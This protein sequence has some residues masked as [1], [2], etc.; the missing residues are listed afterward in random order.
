MREVCLLRIN[1]KIRLLRGM[2]DVVK[3]ALL[4]SLPN[5]PL[6]LASATL[7]VLIQ[8]TQHFLSGAE[9]FHET[10]GEKTVTF[11]NSIR[12]SR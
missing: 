5:Q 1:P 2:I 12:V 10:Q 8:H 3:A 7:K 6:P 9:N 4:Y 11:E